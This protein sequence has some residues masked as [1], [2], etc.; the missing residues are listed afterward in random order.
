MES[1]DRM[2]LAASAA[3]LGLWRWDGNKVWTTEHC[4]RMLG[5]TVDA[6]P[7]IGA[8]PTK[9]HNAERDTLQRQHEQTRR[10]GRPL[11]TVG[12]RL[13][14]DG[15]LRGLSVQGQSNPTP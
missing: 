13:M 7:T 1:E 5:I 6:E 15:G 3:N 4:R 8:L 11:D 9:D 10:W 12:R 14:P 2:R